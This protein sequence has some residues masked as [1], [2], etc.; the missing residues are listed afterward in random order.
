MFTYSNASSNSNTCHRREGERRPTK[1]IQSRKVIQ[2]A[3]ALLRVRCKNYPNPKRVKLLRVSGNKLREKYKIFWRKKGKLTEIRSLLW[4][5]NPFFVSN[6][7][8][9]VKSK[10]VGLYGHTTCMKKMRIYT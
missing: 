6:N 9:T 2:L 1:C 8:M 5:H 3:S 10:R 7:I 4:L